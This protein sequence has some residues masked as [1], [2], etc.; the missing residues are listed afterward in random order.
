MVVRR[1]A[2]DQFISAAAGQPTRCKY[3]VS[4]RVGMFNRSQLVAP[5]WHR[6][7]TSFSSGFGISSTPR[8]ALGAEYSIVKWFPMRFGLSAGGRVGNSS[9]FGLGIGPFSLGSVKLRLFEYAVVNRGGFLPAGTQGMAI[10]L[11]FFRF[12]VGGL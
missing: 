8:V 6:E 4:A 10:S 11:G 12:E 2:H 7:I 9:A 3:V 1:D 5:C